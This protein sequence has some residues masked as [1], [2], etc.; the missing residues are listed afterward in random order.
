MTFT[1]IFVR[2]PVLSTALSL[3]IFLLG[4]HA[5]SMMPVREYPALVNT[6]IS[7]KTAYP[8]ASPNTVQGFITARLEKVIASAP[9]IDYMT[10]DSS[11]GSSTITVYMRLNYSPNAAL[12]NIQSKV[13]QVTDQLPAGSQLPVISVTNGHL[14]DLL[15][16]A[17]YSQELSQQ[18]I[19]DY[20]LRVAQPRLASVPGV[21]EAQIL[22]PGAG[23]G[24]TYAMRVWLNPQ[25][26]AALGITA[27]QV[28]QALAANDFISAVG[29]TR[30]KTVQNTIV[31]TTN[32]VS[33]LMVKPMNQVIRPAPTIDRGMAIAGMSTARKEPR[34]RK[35][36]S[37]TTAR[38]I[39]MV[40]TTSSM[41]AL[42]KVLAS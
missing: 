19:T 40:M 20:L 23:N 13:Q 31:A 42:M 35:M 3:V 7:I 36:T 9:D 15:Y 24:N 30:G 41:E 8:G 26:M 18:Q 10:A 27:A 21:G 22:P 33:R 6:V 14:T 2:R 11:D 34:K 32:R 16:V 5:Y 37:T 4:L 29:Q 17:F 28:S 39:P 38:V 12:A 1:D 25:K